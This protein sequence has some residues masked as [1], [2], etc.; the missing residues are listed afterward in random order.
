MKKEKM[1]KKSVSLE[2]E[3]TQNFKEICDFLDFLII[4]KN[5]LYYYKNKTDI[6]KTQL[7]C[8]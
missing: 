4:Y 1:I 8:H 2:S 5:L 7:E 6:E 3:N